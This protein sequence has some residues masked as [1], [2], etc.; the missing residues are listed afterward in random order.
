LIKTSQA[1]I[2]TA[3]SRGRSNVRFSAML[4]AYQSALIFLCV[5]RQQLAKEQ[6][7]Q[8][9]GLKFKVKP[10]TEQTATIISSSEREQGRQ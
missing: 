9:T 2:D 6:D 3:K 1:L 7:R 5:I 10:N 8:Q 4:G